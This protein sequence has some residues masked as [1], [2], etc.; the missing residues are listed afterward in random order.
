VVDAAQ[1]EEQQTQLHAQIEADASEGAE[2][3]A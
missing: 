2:G 3:E 1:L